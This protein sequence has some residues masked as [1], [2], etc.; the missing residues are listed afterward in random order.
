[1]KIITIPIFFILIFFSSVT[2]FAQSELKS[3]LT[4][5]GFN[6]QE[7][8]TSAADFTLK[9]AGGDNVSLSSYR[10]KVVF[11]NFWTTWCDQCRMEVFSIER[12]Y[13]KLFGEFFEILAVEILESEIQATNLAEEFNL[14]FPMLLDLKGDIA[15]LYDVRA[16]PTTFLI[17]K[18]GRIVASIVGTIEWDNDT[19]IS[20]VRIL[21]EE[22]F[23]ANR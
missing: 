6:V 23:A 2:V 11:L 14:T 13:Q 17:D 10:G 15:T 16:I 3:L 7:Q 19:F 1:M 12:L 8:R 18:K 5:E 22:I 20:A 21:M 9:Q 4:N